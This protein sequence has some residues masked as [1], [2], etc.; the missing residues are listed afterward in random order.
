MTYEVEIN[1]APARLEMRREGSRCTFRLNGDPEQHAD[2]THPEPGVYSILWSGRSYEARVER[3]AGG[4][5]VSV[6]G[7]CCE[8][9]ISDPR[10][11]RG[12]GGA[13]AGGGRQLVTALMPGKVV[14]LLV[15]AGDA[16]DAG[17]GVA[18]VEAMKMQNEMKAQRP[19]KVVSV[20]VREG[21]AVAAGETLVVIE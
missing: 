10:R 7:I 18:V 12:R 11:W 13:A 3:N 21:A 8:V 17:Q 20:T 5:T 16:V 9:R 6:N 4:M 14:R 15:Q 1:G 2:C 19:G